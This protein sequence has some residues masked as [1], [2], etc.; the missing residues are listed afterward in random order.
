[1]S[2]KRVIGLLFVAAAFVFPC[3]AGA[4]DDNWKYYGT[5]KKGERFFYDASSIMRLSGDLIQVWTRELT[6]EGPVK[7]LEEINCS[8]KVMRD[9]Q[10]IYE[11]K[12]RP[13]VRPRTPSNW[14]AMEQD[15]ITK[16]LHKVLCR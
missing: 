15:P 11:G 6:S 7:K 16:E 5:G 8:Y 4:A 13:R 3:G 14:Q 12:Q 9:L 1:M 2:R 10:V